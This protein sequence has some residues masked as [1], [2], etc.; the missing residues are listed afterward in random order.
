MEQEVPSIEEAFG[1]LK[2]P[3]SG[4]VLHGLTEM[5]VVAL[6][7]ILCGADSRVA[8]QIWDEEKL[9]WLRGNLVLKHGIPAHDTFG[10][11]F[12]ALDARRFEACFIRWMK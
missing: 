9:G 6:C 5:L 3:R 10:R 11:V 2:D 4:S 7:A 1:E 8:I 12:A